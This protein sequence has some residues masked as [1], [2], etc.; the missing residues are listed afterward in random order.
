MQTGTELILTS[1]NANIFLKY[2]HASEIENVICRRR[3]RRLFANLTA[4]FCEL[5][6]RHRD[7]QCRNR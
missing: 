1:S 6:T 4:R 7:R 3:R 2:G 5:E